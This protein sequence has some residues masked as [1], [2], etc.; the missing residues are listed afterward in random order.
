MHNYSGQDSTGQDIMRRAA[1]NLKRLT[2]ELGGN[3]AG[4]VLPEP[5]AQP[6]LDAA[7]AHMLSDDAA[8]RQ[9]QAR[10]LAFAGHADIY[11]NAEVAADIILAERK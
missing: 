11:D 3:D 5:F 4:I 8:R 10:G 1:G 6:A 7:L 2:L 9:W